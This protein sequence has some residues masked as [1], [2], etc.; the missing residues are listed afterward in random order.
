[1]YEDY[2]YWDVIKK[3]MRHKREYIGKLD[4]NGQFVPNKSFVAKQEIEKMAKQ[5]QVKSEELKVARNYYGATYLLDT[6][7]ER[8]GIIN[9][10]KVSFPTDYTKILSLAYYLILE[11]D[12][13]MY[14]FSKW[15][16]N[17]KHPFNADIPSQRISEI[18]SSVEESNMN[19]FKNQTNRRS[20][21]EYLAYDTT[22]ISSYSELID[23]VKY[24][25]NKDGESLPQ[26]NLA[27]VFGQTSMLP[28]YFRKLPGNITDV[29]TIRKL[30]KDIEYLNI[31]KVKLVLDRGFISAKNINHMFQNHYKFI[32][33]AKSNIKFISSLLEKSQGNHQIFR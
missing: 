24:R 5:G 18:F 9:D 16:Q 20:E 3:Q 32:I 33:G 14:R 31:N 7:G 15:A 13:P 11:S 4:A 8:S 25:K 22:S 1:M 19:F 30:L 27:L 28:V 23:H 29:M 10:L 12:S 17:H 26:V 6:I 21:K 2:P